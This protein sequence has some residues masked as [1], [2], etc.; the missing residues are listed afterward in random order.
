MKE[1]ERLFEQAGFHCR[2]ISIDALRATFDIERKSS[3]AARVLRQVP[4]WAL[5]PYLPVIPALIY[6]FWY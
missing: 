4:D 6:R 1:L 3:L 5:R 2:N